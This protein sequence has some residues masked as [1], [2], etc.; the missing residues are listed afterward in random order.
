LG[1]IKIIQKLLP[2]LKKSESASVV[3]FST[4]AAKLGMPFHSSI[5]ASKSA[6]EGLDKKFSSRIFAT[7]NK[8]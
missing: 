1:A 3:L 7:K 5:A 6:V 4:V 8:I 2:N